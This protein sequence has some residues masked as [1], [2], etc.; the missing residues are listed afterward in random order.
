M[1]LPRSRHGT[2]TPRLG[3]LSDPSCGL[4]ATGGL[5]GRLERGEGAQGRGHFGEVARS[6]PITAHVEAQRRGARYHIGNQAVRL[7]SQ[8]RGR[9]TALR[10]DLEALP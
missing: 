3:A 2:G 1:P 4:E 6:L 7:Q 8:N 10:R 9:I 5:L